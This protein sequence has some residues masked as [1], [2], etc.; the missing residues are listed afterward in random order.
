M[1]EHRLK[2]RELFIL[3]LRTFRVKPL[4]AILTIA[5]MSV[6]IGAV[7]FLVSLGYGLQFILIGKLVTTEDSLITMEV[8]YPS[9]VDKT[10][11]KSGL[12]DLRKIPE[13]AEVSPIYEFPGEVAQKGSSGLL[14][15]VRIVQ[16]NYFRLSGSYPDVGNSLAVRDDGKS[17]VVISSQALK[18]ISLKSDASSLGKLL[19]LKVFYQD[20]KNL[21]TSEAD[22]IDAMPISGIFSDDSV[23]PLV[24]VLPNSLSKEPPFSRKALVK[25]KDVD[26]VEKVRDAL[27]SK[28]FLVS[29]R[30]DL[31]NQ[32]KKI[33]N[34]ITAVLGVFGVTALIVS[35]IGMF[36]TMI[37]GFM[38]RIYE[39]GVLK[40]IGATDADVRNLFLM[41]SFM[42][43]IFGGIGG[44]ILGVAGGKFFNIALSTLAVRLGGKPFDLFITPLWFIFLIL[45]LSTVIGLVS[46]FWPAHRAAG[47]S[48]KEAFVKR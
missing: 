8:A 25:A 43:G 40:S 45:G 35:A 12:D 14:V 46:G 23:V 26:N 41:E 11:D 30:I 5:G 28:G 18:A 38:E 34:T 32:A 3:S 7:L 1:Y 36:N 47:L 17:G 48:P 20:N 6:G 4:R 44:I 15:D 21:V 27:I 39:V 29:A 37:V 9:E 33:M 13:V 24:V 16:E 19:S 10:I 42:M 22:L 2:F 31:V